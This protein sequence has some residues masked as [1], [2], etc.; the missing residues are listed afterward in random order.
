[1]DANQNTGGGNKVLSFIV[2]AV[3]ASGIMAGAYFGSKEYLIY[4]I[5]NSRNKSKK[6]SDFFD[7]PANA[8][9]AL[10]QCNVFQLYK[11]DKLF[12]SPD[13]LSGNEE[14][15]WSAST[16]ALSTEV[17]DFLKDKIATQQKKAS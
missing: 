9:A 11:V 6:P 14:S 16:K 2:G 4:S 3:V 1:M 7:Q 5:M 17:F 8:Q 15:T 10:K 12:N 13:A